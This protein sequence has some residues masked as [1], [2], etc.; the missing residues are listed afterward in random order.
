LKYN[1]YTYTKVIVDGNFKNP[2]FKGKVF[3]N[4]PNL[5]LDFNG[6]VNLGKKDIAY[7]FETKID[8][9][10]L[11]QLNFVKKDSIAIFKGDIKV[12]VSGNSLDDLK[13]DIHF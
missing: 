11:H 8:Y 3:I 5:F 12:N 4:D 10:N 6:S 1:G 7:D 13:G 9:A 2:V